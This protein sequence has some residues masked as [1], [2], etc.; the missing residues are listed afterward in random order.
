[1]CPTCFPRLGLSADASLS[2]TGSSGASSPASTVLS[3]RYDFLPPSRRASFPSLGGTSVSLVVFALCQPSALTEPGV[4]DPVS[5]TGIRR[6]T[7]RILPSSWGTS[8][9]RLPCS[10][11]TPA[12]LLTPD[13]IVQQRGPWSSQGKGSHVWDFRRSI[14]WPSDS[15]STLRSVDY[16]NTTQDS[17]P[18]A[19]QAL[20]D[21]LL[22]RKVPMKGFKLHLILLSQACLAQAMQPVPYS[23]S[24]PETTFHRPPPTSLPQSAGHRASQTASILR[25]RDQAPR[26]RRQECQFSHGRSPH[27]DNRD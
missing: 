12:G 24:Q 7:S 10:K 11:P 1:M 14:A 23:I 4:V 17:L 20:L 18:A 9:V 2:S 13:H 19:G 5:P 26:A 21:G 25:S 6:G 27:A 22:T 16:S 3:K 15:L 8:M